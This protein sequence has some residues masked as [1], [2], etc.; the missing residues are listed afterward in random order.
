MEDRKK[1]G[2]IGGIRS[3]LAGLMIASGLRVA[4]RA[5]NY[6]FSLQSRDQIEQF[7]NQKTH[8]KQSDYALLINA[9]GRAEGRNM[10]STE[11]INQAYKTLRNRGFNDENIILVTPSIPA[12]R[13]LNKGITAK[14]SRGN[15]ELIKQYLDENLTSNS[16]LVV[17]YSGHQG[18]IKKGGRLQ[19]GNSLVSSQEFSDYF[20]ELPGKKIFLLN[21]CYAGYLGKKI[22]RIS[23]DKLVL[24]MTDD[25]NNGIM[26]FE[27]DI[28]E[29]I[30]KGEPIREAYKN[31]LKKNDKN[32]RNQLNKRMGGRN[33]YTE[34]SS[35]NVDLPH[36]LNRATQE[37]RNSSKSTLEE[38]AEN[39]L[40]FFSGFIILAYLSITITGNI[41]STTTQEYLGSS[42]FFL[43]AVFLM[44]L[45]LTKKILN[46]KKNN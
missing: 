13:D 15:L 45:V 6:D 4:D 43:S 31:A 41:I 27:G 32:W 30:D 3:I 20:K 24:C 44:V 25:K 37:D 8:Q 26:K 42:Y 17:S 22:D 5:V 46:K 21:T 11:M 40:L 19:I 33:I 29:R 14:P 23:G 38:R 28:W 39:I 16:T 10:G 36:P 9:Q 2:L 35:G 18:E 12:G 34:Y 1:A 7:L